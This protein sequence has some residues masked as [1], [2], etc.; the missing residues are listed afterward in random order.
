MA[1]QQNYPTSNSGS[2][3]FNLNICRTFQQPI[4]TNTVALS[5]ETIANGFP[6]SEVI[7]MNR[8]GGVIYIWDNGYHNAAHENFFWQLD[9][10]E[11]FTFRG[12]TNVN[13]VSAAKGSGS[14]EIFYRTQY[15]SS[16][17][18]R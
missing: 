12:L 16:N 1:E 9:D 11:Q 2:E 6:C 4:D 17:P 10:N 5:G 18:S 13:Q 8:T 15:F 14:G 3:Y 7:L